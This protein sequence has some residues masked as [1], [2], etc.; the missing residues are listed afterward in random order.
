MLAPRGGGSERPRR[1]EQ[2]DLAGAPSGAPRTRKLNSTLSR[3][4]AVEHRRL[5][6][7]RRVMRR[8]QETREPDAAMGAP[9]T[10]MTALRAALP[11]ALQRLSTRASS[12]GTARPDDA[13]ASRHRA[14][15]AR[16]GMLSTVLA[17]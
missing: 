7:H 16:R 4:A 9:S 5:L 8:E 6:E 15:I 3:D 17:P 13:E 10:W 11:K 1:L 12:A 2:Q 14:E